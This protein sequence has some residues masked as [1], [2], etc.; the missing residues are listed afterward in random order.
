MKKLTTALFLAALC[1]TAAHAQDKNVPTAA[2]SPAA[3]ATQAAPLQVKFTEETHDFG[4]VPEGPFAEYDFVFKNTGKTPVTIT[5][6]RSTCGCT[7]P[8]WPHEPVLPGKTGELHVRYTTANH[9]GPIS[10]AITVSFADQEKPVIL[11]IAGTVTAKPA[12]ATP[13]AGTAN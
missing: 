2:Q 4:Q 7:V 13:A 10:K 8:T 12:P 5:N 9:Q 1:T 11:H 3:A 6:A